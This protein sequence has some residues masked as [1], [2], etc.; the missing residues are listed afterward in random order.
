MTH[1]K[2][3]IDNEVAMDGDTGAVEEHAAHR[4]FSI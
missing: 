1:I 4:R 3:V 2:L